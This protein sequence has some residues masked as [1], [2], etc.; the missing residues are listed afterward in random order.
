MHTEQ[1]YA[2]RGG[3]WRGG[4]WRGVAGRGR[5]FRRQPRVNLRAVRP[6]ANKVLFPNSFMAWIT[7]LLKR[8]WRGERGG[9]VRGGERESTTQ[10]ERPTPHLGA[11]GRGRERERER[12]E[13]SER[14]SERESEQRVSGCWESGRQVRG[15]S[16]TRTCALGAHTERAGPKSQTPQPILAGPSTSTHMC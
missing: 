14:E 15:R 4:A 6:F 2:G 11:I 10:R 9:V 5:A 3:A 7:R 12:R 1:H 8:K 16:A 13:E